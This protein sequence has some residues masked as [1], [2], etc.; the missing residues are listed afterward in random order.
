M[1]CRRTG[2]P[3][4]SRNRT[5]NTTRGY[6]RRSGRPS[7]CADPEDADLIVEAVT[8]P[9]KE[10]VR[11]QR[12]VD[13]LQFELDTAQDELSHANWELDAARGPGVSSDSVCHDIRREVT[14]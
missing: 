2:S 7:P 6:A 4:A 8:R 3:N 12:R 14:N 5:L 9:P 11:L 1:S 13:D 10:L